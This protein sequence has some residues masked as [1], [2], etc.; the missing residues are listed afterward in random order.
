[1]IVHYKNTWDACKKSHKEKK[2]TVHVTAFN[3]ICWWYLEFCDIHAET[4]CCIKMNE[5]RGDSLKGIPQHTQGS[6]DVYYKG[7]VF[8]NDSGENY[9]YN[10]QWQPHTG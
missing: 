10:K 9:Q 3:E 2:S 6:Y 4:Y 1:M 8:L 5:S 7:D